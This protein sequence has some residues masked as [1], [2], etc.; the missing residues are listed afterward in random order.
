MQM[1]IAVVFVAITAV[2]LPLAAMASQRQQAEVAADGPAEDIDVATLQRQSM[3]IHSVLLGLALASVWALQLPLAWYAP[4]T[5]TQIALGALVVAVFVLIALSEA[6]RAP[7]DPIR[8]AFRRQPLAGMWA[9]TTLSAAVAEEVVYRA[10]LVLVLALVVP[11]WLAVLLSAVAFAS[12]HLGQGWSGFVISA[13]FALAMQGLLFLSGALLL[14]ILVH[15][16][17]DLGVAVIARSRR[18][19]PT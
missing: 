14:P 13:V 10:A 17:Y 5:W 12:G 15:L 6:K 4:P 2:L 8:A 3:L 9:L 18:K 19:S 16:A 7:P 1:L 11:F